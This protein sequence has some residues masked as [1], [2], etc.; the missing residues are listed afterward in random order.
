MAVMSFTPNFGKILTAETMIMTCNV[1]AKIK[2]NQAYVWYK[3]GN[4]M[5]ITQQTFTIENALVSDSGY[6]QCQSTNTHMSE[7]LR[8]DVSNCNLIVQTPPFTLEGD[9]LNLTCHHRQGLDLERTMFYKNGAL[10][11]ILGTKSVMTLGNAYY[12]MTGEYKCTKNTRLSSLSY[13]SYSA[14]LYVPISESWLV[15]ALE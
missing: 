3:D 4:Q 2:D 1:D 9:E 6:Y 12:N 11:K 13:G 15:D 14:Y 7:P 10:L 8:L 5:N